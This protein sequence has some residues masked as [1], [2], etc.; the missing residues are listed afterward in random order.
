M[1]SFL[2]LKGIVT[3]EKVSGLLRNGLLFVKSPETFWAN[4]I[5]YKL[6]MIYIPC[7]VISALLF[8]V[9]I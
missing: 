9:Y 7:T 6:F 8:L 4:K 5:F 3:A 2:E 1:F